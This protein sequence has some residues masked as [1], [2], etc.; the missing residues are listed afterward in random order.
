MVEHVPGVGDAAVQL[1]V[2]SLAPQLPTP[3]LPL[4]LPLHAAA[5]VAGGLGAAQ[6]PVG[7]QTLG[8]GGVGAAPP[9]AAAAHQVWPQPLLGVVEEMVLKVGALLLLL[10][11]GAV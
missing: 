8:C 10:L 2:H 3:R 1:A 5:A 11:H 7:L 6:L 4:L 9:A